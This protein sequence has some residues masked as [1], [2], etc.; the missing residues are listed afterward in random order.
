MSGEAVTYKI[1]S[2]QIENFMRISAAYIEPNGNLIEITGK[3][4]AGKSS[5]LNA[6]WSLIDG[7]SAIPKQ[8]IRKGTEK[9]VIR[10]DLGDLIV[11]RKFNAKDDDEY[12]T[13]LTVEAADGARYPKQQ[14]ILNSIKG[15]L[16]FDPLAVLEMTP[17]QQFE[18]FRKFVPEIDFD[19]IEGLNRRDFEE[20]TNV[21]RRAKELRA[22][23]AGLQIPE[24]PPTERVDDSALVDALQKAGEHNA[25]I[26]RESSQR[27]QKKMRA[28]TLREQ[29]SGQRA[30]AERLRL[31]A[32]DA[33]KAAEVF[34]GDAAAIER[35]LSEAPPLPEAINTAL[36]RE[37]INRAQEQN[38][39]FDR[40]QTRRKLEETAAEFEA[41]SA[42]LTTAIETR[43]DQMR[44]E[45]EAADMPVKGISLADGVVTFNGLP[46]DQASRA[47]QLRVS[48]AIAAALNPKLKMALVRDGSLLD[49]ESWSLLKELA[50]QFDFQ[51]FIETVESQRPGAIV[52]EDGHI[53]LAEAAE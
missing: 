5:I 9:A 22:Q 24:N 39:I 28:A 27:D 36:A 16:S 30:H 11:T 37:R 52:I 35:E 10:A 19:K 21:N 7:K 49:G 38:V 13:S 20:R 29:A 12:T 40:L 33:E 26:E 32:E 46:F 48:V 4:G 34:D 43:A 17:A 41:K 45:I 8:P 44:A 3:N 31:Q 53:K 51:V 2:L 1:G 25:A 42:E 18:T 47:E 14:D 6:I 50:D 15:A 23:A